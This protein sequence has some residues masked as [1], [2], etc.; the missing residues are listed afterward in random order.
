M[1]PKKIIF[2]SPVTSPGCHH[3]TPKNVFIVALIIFGCE[4][5]FFHLQDFVRY[6]ESNKK[7]P[8]WNVSLNAWTEFERK[9]LGFP[10]IVE[11]NGLKE[12]EI[13]LMFIRWKNEE[14]QK[15][16]I[17]DCIRNMTIIFNISRHSYDAQNI[18]IALVRNRNISVIQKYFLRRKWELKNSWDELSVVFVILL[19]A[20][21]FPLVKQ[22]VSGLI[23]IG[24]LGAF[25]AS[26][27]WS[28]GFMDFRE[29]IILHL[30]MTSRQDFSLSLI[31]RMEKKSLE[32]G[33]IINTNFSIAYFAC[34]FYLISWLPGFTTL[35]MLEFHVGWNCSKNF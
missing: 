25:R 10:V 13:F 26:C 11:Q 34:I 14:I 29:Q 3:I 23:I 19:K 15:C 8:W 2:H 20:S 6:W 28:F 4:D 5:A 7:L 17:A 27:E 16:K 33:K 35:L 30:F 9:A 31:N 18:S 12:M 24:G 22:S 32:R 1:S 21:D